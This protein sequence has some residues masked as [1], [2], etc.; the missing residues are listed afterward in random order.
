[1][2]ALLGSLPAFAAP[3]LDATTT[4]PGHFTDRLDRRPVYSLATGITGLQLL[5]AQRFAQQLLCRGALVVA[6][7]LSQLA[8]RREPQ[9]RA[10]AS[11]A[12]RFRRATKSAATRC[13]A[14]LPRARP[15]DG[16]CAR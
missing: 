14:W 3:F 2:K 13:R 5:G 9:P 16:L 1:M 15:A 11:N 7:A 10:G 8:S 4:M 12:A 6:V